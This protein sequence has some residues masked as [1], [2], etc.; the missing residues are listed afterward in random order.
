MKKLTTRKFVCIALIVFI[1]TIVL[2][3]IYIEN[4]VVRDEPKESD[5]MITDHAGKVSQKVKAVQKDATISVP[6]IKSK[7]YDPVIQTT[8]TSYIP[9]PNVLGKSVTKNKKCLLAIPEDHFHKIHLVVPPPGTV[10]LVCCNTTKGILNIAVH[11]DWAPN[12]AK[13]FLEMVNTNFFESKVPLFRALKGFL[14][15]FGLAGTPEIQRDINI[16]GWLIDDPSW[17]P[18]GPKFRIV[19]GV[20][21]YQKG[22]M[23][24]AG[25]GKNSRGTQLIMAFNSNE[26]LGIC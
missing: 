17:L 16:K 26:G 15:Q 21:R 1:F 19:D 7:L 5:N 24:Y 14:V 12:G 23:G 3:I 18:F 2:C 6:I 4:N 22:Y 9:V 13:R 20:K 8:K 11:L 25:G 10:T